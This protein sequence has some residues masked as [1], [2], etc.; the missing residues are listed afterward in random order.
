MSKSR[1]FI[2][3]VLL[4]FF[5]PAFAFVENNTKIEYDFSSPKSIVTAAKHL[6]VSGDFNEMLKITENSEKRK[7]ETTIISVKKNP[8]LKMRLKEESKRVRKFE[9]IKEEIFTSSKGEI[10]VV[11]TRWMMTK[12]QPQQIRGVKVINDPT[13]KRSKYTTVYVDYLLRKFDGKWKI[14]SRRNK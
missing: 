12:V 13:Q 10:A 3:L 6:V 1:I 5:I 9:V 4:V 2:G 14:V 8:K 7:T 11:Y